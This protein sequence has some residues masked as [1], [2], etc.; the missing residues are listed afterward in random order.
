MFEWISKIWRKKITPASYEE[1]EKR[2]LS[3]NFPSMKPTQEFQVSL[4]DKLLQRFSAKSA[5]SFFVKRRS[6]F[7]IALGVFILVVAGW[8]FYSPNLPDSIE[9]IIRRSTISLVKAGT[10]A[11][12]VNFP[13]R[14]GFS[15]NIQQEALQKYFS[16]TPAI[17]GTVS[18]KNKILTF[19]HPKY[20]DYE[21]EYTLKVAKEASSSME[22]DFEIT[23][24][25]RGNFRNEF[26]L[27]SGVDFAHYTVNYYE[28]VPQVIIDSTFDEGKYKTNLYK[29]TPEKVVDFVLKVNSDYEAGTKEETFAPLK[30]NLVES[31]EVQEESRKESDGKGGQ[32]IYKPGLKETGIYFV[33]MKGKPGKYDDGV[34]RFFLTYSRYAASTKYLGGELVNW[35]VDMQN[36]KGVAGAKIK[37]FDKDK[38]TVFEDRTDEQ[39]IHKFT[40]GD[41]SPVIEMLDVNGEVLINILNFRYRSVVTSS[42]WSWAGCYSQKYS[43]Y[44]MTDRPLY[45]PGDKV[46]FKVLLRKKGE[47]KYDGSIK[48]AEVEVRGADY[49]TPVDTIFKNDYE[50]N[51]MGTFAGEF[52]LGKELATGQY[53]LTV[54]VGEEIV[55]VYQ[56]GVEVFQ[57]PD[58]EVKVKANKDKYISGQSVSVDVES[59]YF[60]GTPV[61]G[62]KVKVEIAEWGYYDYGEMLVSKEGVLDQNGRLSLTFDNVKIE[63]QNQYW[64][65]GND[66]RTLLI[67]ATVKENTGKEVSKSMP[68]AFYT[69]E[70]SVKLEEPKNLWRFLPREKTKMVFRVTRNLDASE[71]NGAEGVEIKLNFIKRKWNS[72]ETFLFE[73]DKILKTDLFG[74]VQLETEFPVGGSYLLKYE[75][76]DSKGN[77]T[78]YEDYFWIPDVEN[79]VTYDESSPQNTVQIALLTDKETYKVGEKARV[80]AY[81]PQ[82]EGDLFVSANAG[83][84]EYVLADSISGDTKTFEVPITGNMVPGF[85]LFAEVYNSG[86]FLTGTKFVEVTGKKLSVEITSSKKQLYPKE[87]VILS[88]A[89]KDENGSPVASEGAISVI[90]KAILALRAFDKTSLFDAFYKKP[91]EQDLGRL[92]SSEPFVV[93]AAEM[94]GCFLGNTKISMAD[95]SLKN[96]EDIKIGDVILTREN[97]FS[98]RLSKDTVVRKFEH[99]VGEYL[100]INGSL[101]VT[102]VHRM[103]VNGR[104]KTAGEIRTGDF[105]V[106]FNGK[107]VRVNSIQKVLSRVKVYNFET[108]RLHTY[109]ADS[110]YVHN[111]KGGGDVR[112]RTNFVDTAYWNAFVETGSD[113]RGEIKFSLPDNLTTWVAL[114]KNITLDT[115][116]GEGEAEFIVSKDLFIRPALPL[117]FRSGDEADIISTI[118]NTGQEELRV[119]ALLKTE[120]AAITNEA[121]QEISAPANGTAQ[122]VWKIEVGNSKELHLAFSVNQIGGELIDNLEHKLPVYP[123]LTLNNNV[124]AGSAPVKALKFK[125]DKSKVTAFDSAVLTLNAS[126]VAILPEVIE[127]LTGY[128]YGCVEQTMSKHLPNVLAKKYAK[129]LGITIKEDMDKQLGDGLDRLQK[130]Q[131][132]DGSFGWWESDE[133]NVWM[134]GYVLEG[135]LE[136]KELGMLSSDREAMYARTLEYLQK[137]YSASVWA[138]DAKTYVAYVLS[139]AL[140]GKIKFEVT[141]EELA[142][143][144]PQFHGYAALVH[145]FNNNKNE[146]K[147]IVENYILPKLTNNHWEQTND[148][149]S[150]TDSYSA[151]G[152]NLFA[153]LTIGG[154]D[155]STV[156][157]IVVWLMNHR[158]GYEGLW[159]STRQSSQILFALIKYI[160][161][162]NEFDPEL[163]YTIELNGNE[164]S[165]GKIV[166]SKFSKKI[167]IPVEK[168]STGNSLN[169][170]TEGQGSLFYTLQVK[171]Y[172]SAD[173]IEKSAE[174]LKITRTYLKDGKPAQQFNVGDVLTVEIAIESPKLL[175]YVMIEDALP[176]GFDVIN[177]RLK[178]RGGM[179]TEN[180]WYYWSNPVDIRDEKV[181]IFDGYVE[182]GVTRF[183]YRMRAARKGKF[184]VP[185]SRA[186]PMYDP[187]FF[188]VGAQE[189]LSIK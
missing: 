160:Q 76:T 28:S 69:S 14:V 102:S 101:K 95:G 46:Q 136:I 178:D 77:K 67:K 71:N 32:V 40:Y 83:S 127:K 182:K 180:E 80:T 181:A 86:V 53:F 79:G 157:E 63:Q 96:I 161:T 78:S 8:F 176:S 164:L 55:N 15:Y 175:S 142:G 166:N 84:V 116:V 184:N 107:S 24:T 186:E 100:V 148:Y 156:K 74:K 52:N 179:E 105:F 167:E 183:N 163:N 112:P 150:M 42:C 90:D 147:R 106:D 165:E 60:F 88:V 16:I 124:M 44:V 132:E 149:N 68:V 187:E 54:K 119:K 1:A 41:F 162:Y 133:A 51:S 99:I 22:K 154:A 6:A 12:A 155:E 7:G 19:N 110:V 188:G 138:K 159:G 70:Y 11:V 129:L 152:V 48:T 141:D 115:K 185:S 131:H 146:A 47:S 10:P 25:T 108:A 122:V 121:L 139:R 170:S 20:L 50:V 144:Q 75:V 153:L 2:L 72:P 94:G 140:P 64:W 145:Y 36:A 151:T 18:L 137:N 13:I 126:V 89:T 33:E 49:G 93:G 113:G 172:I 114:G 177:D 135:L 103:F 45:S 66:S 56:F 87:E 62:Q 5:Q 37:A 85:F 91:S 123:S 173:E 21:T 59:K 43:S 130:M 98:S 3:S 57:K 73:Q 134:T 158:Q 143:L 109:F 97:D 61:K 168:L 58:F 30:Q 23:F 171:N 35:V 9:H 120:G 128:P 125:F 118:H 81:L 17:E 39:G 29:V 4:K 174:A 169:I 189:Q 65:W 38:K 104:W 92:L 31:S 82:E 117:F 26:Y 111:D 27:S 34:Y